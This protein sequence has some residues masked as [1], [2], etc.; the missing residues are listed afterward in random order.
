MNKIS[1]MELKVGDRFTLTP[2]S[3]DIWLV[4]REAG[5]GAYE[6][7]LEATGGQMALTMAQSASVYLADPPLPEEGSE[8]TVWG[9]TWVVASA[10]RLAVSLREMRGEMVVA[11]LQLVPDYFHRIVAPEPLPK[12][13][14]KRA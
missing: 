1:A 6:A 5:S 7:I 4:R 3:K 8:V 12:N 11:T 14:W 9:H 10:S 2:G 13:G